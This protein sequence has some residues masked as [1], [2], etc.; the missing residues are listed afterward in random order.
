MLTT[1]A[2]WGVDWVRHVH[3]AAANLALILIPLHVLGVILSSVIER[4]NLVRAMVTG[5]K[6]A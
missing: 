1:D 3:S 6:R 5:R 2:F 4:E